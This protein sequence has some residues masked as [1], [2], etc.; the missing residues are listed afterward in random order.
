[1]WRW[2]YSDEHDA[3]WCWVC[4]CT[5]LYLGKVGYRKP[6]QAAFLPQTTF[7]SADKLCTSEKNCLRNSHEP[8]MM[9]NLPMNRASS[10]QSQATTTL[11]IGADVNKPKCH[12]PRTK[13]SGLALF[14]QQLWLP[15]TC[16]HCSGRW[17]WQRN[18]RS[19]QW[20]CLHQQVPLTWA[21]GWW[22]D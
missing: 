5:M 13:C 1:M 21:A 6:K 19:F 15:S 11:H 12:I 3:G 4:P 9:Q 17:R 10:S 8:D 16:G 2:T 18:Y 7:N 20:I 14:H 22:G